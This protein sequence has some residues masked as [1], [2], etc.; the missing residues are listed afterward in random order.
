MPFLV[1]KFNLKPSKR[2]ILSL[3]GFTL[4]TQIIIMTLSIY[5]LWKALIMIS[6]FLYSA[7]IIYRHG[8]LLSPHSIQILS[9]EKKSWHIQIEGRKYEVALIGESTV[10]SVVCILCFYVLEKRKRISCVI[11]PDSL[12]PDQYRSLLVL[13]KLARVKK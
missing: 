13:V 9:Y 2:Y 10:S 11:L 12:L 4:L 1:T 8:F 3:F 6:S 7:W 5:W